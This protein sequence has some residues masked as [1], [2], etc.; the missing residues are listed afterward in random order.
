MFAIW[1][2]WVAGWGLGAGATNTL[3]IGGEILIILILAVLAN[4]IAK[5][6]LLAALTRIIRASETKLDDVFLERQVFT[7]LSHLAPALVI[8]LVGPVAFAAQ[9]TLTT[10]CLR[11]AMV[12]ILVMAILV[13]DA[14][15]NALVDIYRGTEMGAERPIKG[16]VQIVKIILYLAIGIVIF[17]TILDRSPIVMLSGLGAMTAVLL[18]IFKDAILGFVAGIQISAND[19]LRP[20]DWIEM[21]KY[22]ADGDVLEVSLT[23][24]KVRNW[25]KTIATIPTYALVS[26]AFRNWRGM[27]ESGGRRIKRALNIDL[28]TIR[29]L[30]PNEAARFAKVE[31]LGEYIAEKEKEVADWNENQRTD[32]GEM[33]NGRR[34]TNV[35]T[36][37]AY[38]VNYLRAHPMIHDEMTFLVRHLPPTEHGLPIEI[39]VFSRDQAWVSYEAIQA[40]IFDHI[41]AVVPEFGLRVFQRPSGTDQQGLS[42]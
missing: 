19:M 7:R 17:S 1:R 18:L 38:V 6:I 8:Y 12:Y 34:L 5:R 40:D 39:Y 32:L 27:E 22:G 3:T 9:P 13:I 11:G 23:T 26:D 14:F 29:F 20:G 31:Y 41:L 35:G 28:S 37:R 25:D 16:Y 21:S 33:I 10:I 42:T 30:T 24:V 2:E 15:L 4:F 36:F